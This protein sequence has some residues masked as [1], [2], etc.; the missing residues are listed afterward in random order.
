MYRRVFETRTCCR[1]RGNT[2]AVRY[3]QSTGSFLEATGRLSREIIEDARLG[4][5]C[6]SGSEGYGF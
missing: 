6:E 1:S 4:S 3:P 2:V 5:Y